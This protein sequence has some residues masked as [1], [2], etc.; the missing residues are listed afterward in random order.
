LVCG[1]RMSTMEVM[2]GVIKPREPKPKVAKPPK[3][4]TVKRDVERSS[5]IK[6]EKKKWL[7][8]WMH[9]PYSNPDLS[10]LGINLDLDDNYS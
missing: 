6:R 10:D 7:E 1:Q 8:D 4:T 5:P 3:K 2:V 9:D